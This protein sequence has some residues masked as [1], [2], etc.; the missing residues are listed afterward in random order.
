MAYQF[1]TDERFRKIASKIADSVTLQVLSGR[2]VS[3]SDMQCLCPMGCLPDAIQGRPFSLPKSLVKAGI[4]R[5]E[6]WSFV[7][8]F[9]NI[10]NKDSMEDPEEFRELGK[11]YRKRYP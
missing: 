1:P 8:G 2:E 11:L 3:A 5:D 7:C 6:F 10:E 9:G 4:T